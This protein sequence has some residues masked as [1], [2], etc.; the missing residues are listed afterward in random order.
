M[1]VGNLHLYLKCHSSTGENG[2]KNIYLE[3]DLELTNH[4]DL[5]WGRKVRFATIIVVFKQVSAFR[6]IFGKAGGD[7][8]VFSFTNSAIVEPYIADKFLMFIHSWL[9]LRHEFEGILYYESEKCY[10]LAI[11]L[12][13]NKLQ[14]LT[15]RRLTVANAHTP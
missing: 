2:L 11:R 4:V 3:A 8:T 1:Q 13:H 12:S 9:K 10:I 7:V 5:K 6:R 15:L 14:Q